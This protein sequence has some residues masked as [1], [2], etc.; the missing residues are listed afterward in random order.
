MELNKFKITRNRQRPDFC[1]AYEM[2]NESKT[3]KYSIFT[4][5]GGNSFLASVI[6]ANLNGK[7][8]DTDFQT[9]VTTPEEG[10]KEIKNFLDNGK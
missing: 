10:L 2:Y 7:L 6:T 4:I 5:D 3:A 9:M 8:V 1:Y